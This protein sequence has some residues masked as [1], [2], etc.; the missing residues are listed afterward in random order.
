MLSL[1]PQ[2]LTLEQLAPFILRLALGVIFI[3]HGY[4]KLFTQF[5]GTAQ[6]FESVGIK[7]AKFW[8]FVVGAVEFF[9]GILLVAGFL[10]Q[11]AAFLLAV[12]MLVA[13]WKLKFKQGLVGGYEFDLALLAVALALLVL[14]PGAFSLDLPL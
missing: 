3:A 7:P 2:L 14:G 4:P 6:F 12:N 11:P 5:S 10:T 8:V 1:F 9:G 13:I